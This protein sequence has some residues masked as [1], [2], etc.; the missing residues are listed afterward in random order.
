MKQSVTQY[1]MEYHAFRQNIALEYIN[2]AGPQFASNDGDN[3]FPS[4]K[5][6]F[7]P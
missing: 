1:S 2:P 7:V 3:A 5:V 6:L 4:V